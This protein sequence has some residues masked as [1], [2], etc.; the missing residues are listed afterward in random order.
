MTDTKQDAAK[1]AA[2]RFAASL[3]EAD[4]VVGLGTGS[5]AAEALRALGRRVREER[6]SFVGI[7]TSYAS[8]R[9]ARELGIRLVPVEDVERLDLALD[10]ADEIDPMLN[11]IKGGG[12]AHSREKVIAS[13]ADR[14]VVVGDASKLVDRLGTRAPVPVEIIPM[15]VGSV[16][17]ALSRLGAVPILR[18][19]IKKDGPVVTDQGL[20]II[21]A[22]F[23]PID[24]PEALNRTL[25]ALPGVLDHGLFLGMSTLAVIGEADGSVRRL[26]PSDVMPPVG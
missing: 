2:G 5:T 25:H 15:A 6:L 14:F 11:L 10:G 23:G 7:P 21:D 20:W 16:S 1:I 18:T 9:L 13:M 8:E 22:Q 24:D 19:G 3:V 4:M 17:R 26:E 12:A